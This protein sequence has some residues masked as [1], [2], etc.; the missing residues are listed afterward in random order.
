[1]KVFILNC[2]PHAHGATAAA[3]DEVR[4]TLENEGVETESFH[5]GTDPIQPCVS[6]MQCSRTGRCAF[7][8]GVNQV[9]EKMQTADGLIVGTPVHYAATSGSASVFLDR[10]F[11]AGGKVFH[12]KPAA[13]VIC[14]RRAGAT[15][16]LDE[17]NKYF[18]I[19]QMPI[20]S[21]QYWNMVF[22]RDAEEVQQDL[23]G[24]QTMRTLA[25]NMAWLLRCIQAGK[26][27]GIAPPPREKLVR[28]NFIR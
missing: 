11:F 15:N 19:S 7:E 5:I 14:C 8:D 3:L 12:H 10:L 22:G 25:R 9:I 4:R 27:A 28:T 18:T 16:A 24:M 23:E 20:V 21:S 13:G 2:S 6:C 26:E 17:L 1:M